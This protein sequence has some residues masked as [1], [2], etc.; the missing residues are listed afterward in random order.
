[1]AAQ[2]L[3]IHLPAQGARVPSLSWEDATCLRAT[4]PTHIPEPALKSPGALDF[5]A[6]GP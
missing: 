3:R 5:E 4:K 1:M 6:H 2:W